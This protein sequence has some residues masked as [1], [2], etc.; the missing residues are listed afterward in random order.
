MAL[1]EDY[2]SIQVFLIVLRE[3]LETAV[4]ISVLLAF[5]HK[6]FI[7]SK[8]NKEP[9]VYGDQEHA[10]IA[11]SEST[12]ETD[13]TAKGDELAIYNYLRLQIW[14]GGLLGLLC[15]LVFG[16]VILAVF[17]IVGN[18]LWAV[19]EHYWEGAFSI[20]AS[21]IIS[22]M[23]VKI[24]RVNKMQKKWK[25]KLAA[26]IHRS[27]YLNKAIRQTKRRRSITEGFSVWSEKYSMFILPFI[28]TLREGM[29]AIVFIG[30]IGINENTSVAAIVN[31]T[32]FAIILGAFIGVLLYR[33]GN[34]LPLQWFL[35]VS[36][37]FL[38]LV[39]AGLFSKGVWNFE[40]QRFIDNCD[41]FDVSETGHG[42]GSYDIATSVW[43]VNCCNGEI[44]EDG[45]FWMVVTAIFGWTNSA[46]YGS[47]ISY[48]VYWFVVIAAFTSL[49]YEERHGQLPF[50]PLSWQQRRIAKK[51]LAYEPLISPE[52]DIVQGLRASIDSV[53][54]TTPLTQA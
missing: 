4:I 11:N 24:L 22:V 54:S 19:T 38:Y 20:L 29:E 51:R 25:S 17:Y 47:V 37:S 5:I 15:C 36:T 21:V 7:S 23:G 45:A 18:D 43:H 30:G 2:F 39:A 26:I 40:L 49:I 31:S 6:S 12:H 27:D 3:A 34:T 42:P 53:N 44:Q 32:V 16:S 9:P 46:T 48:N 33:S 50:I 1:F 28:T 13:P 14:L 8:S 41:G 10:S 35:I 52:V